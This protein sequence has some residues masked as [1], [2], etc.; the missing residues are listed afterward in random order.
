MRKDITPRL[1]TAATSLLLA[2][3][4]QAEMTY[5]NYMLSNLSPETEGI[6]FCPRQQITAVIQCSCKKDAE[7]DLDAY[8]FTDGVCSQWHTSTLKLSVGK[9]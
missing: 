4:T 3:C 6:F 7:T 9:I 2:D 8:S 5:K 1:A